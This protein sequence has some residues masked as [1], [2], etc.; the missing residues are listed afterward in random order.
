MAPTR[1]HTGGCEAR[2]Q[3]IR[4]AQGFSCRAKGGDRPEHQYR[5][6]ITADHPK[7][8]VE[9]LYAGHTIKKQQLWLWNVPGQ[10]G[11]CHLWTQQVG[12]TPGPPAVAGTFARMGARAQ[13]LLGQLQSEQ[14]GRVASLQALQAQ[15]PSK[16]R[17]HRICKSG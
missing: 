5:C 7:I 10:Y 15:P 16:N 8:T 12:S 1:C 2:E 13:S 4:K 14:R 17:P 11:E 9:H 6:R 3:I